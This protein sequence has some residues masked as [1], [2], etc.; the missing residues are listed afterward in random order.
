MSYPSHIQTLIVEDEHGPIENYRHFFQDL[1][2]LD[3][4]PPVIVSSRDDAANCLSGNSI[5]HLIIIDLGLPYATREAAKDGVEPGIE[6]LQ[7]AATREKYPIPAALVISGRLGQAKLPSLGDYLATKFWYGKMVNKGSGEEEEIQNAMD[8]VRIYC[9][10]GIHVCDGAGRLC[11]TVSPREEDLLRRCVLAQTQCIGLD[12][13]WWGTY[14]G[15][16][17]AVD[18][19]MNLMTKVLMGRFLLRDG[20]D[21]SRPSFFKFE[22]KESA[23]T[24]H[25]AAAIMVHKLGHMKI[26]SSIHSANRSLLVTQQVG[27]SS[28]PPISLAEMLTKNAEIA[29]KA[30]PQV[31]SDIADQL[32]SLGAVTDNCFNVSDLLWPCHNLETVRKAWDRHGKGREPVPVRL[33][34]AL[35]ISAQQI[36]VRRQSCTHGDLNATNIALEEVDGGYRGYIFDAAGMKADTAMRDL[37]MLEVTSLL[38]QPSPSCEDLVFKC[39]SLYNDGVTMPA[40]ALSEE[41]SQIVRNTFHLIQEIRRHALSPD[42][43]PGYALMVFDCAMIQLGGLAIQSHQNKITNP[44]SAVKLAELA[45][46]W[47]LAVAPTLAK[48]PDRPNF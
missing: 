1:A 46:N 29:A 25:E 36:W 8:K 31:V 11:P 4:A 40:V 23:I 12:I 15:T 44:E 21:S 18:P 2:K 30:I 43:A 13:E 14:P 34:E 3:V 10:V 45:A 22:P 27:G 33:L 32:A 20:K 48:T 38:H 41:T 9:N 6:L 19:T 42:N 5:Y 47:L 35:R 17:V 39:Q 37:A 28:N 7:L 24:S 16:S 26:C